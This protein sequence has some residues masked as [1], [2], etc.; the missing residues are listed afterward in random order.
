MSET[1]GVD[2]DGFAFVDLLVEAEPWWSDSWAYHR[3]N[4]GVQAPAAFLRT[5]AMLGTARLAA[6]G[7]DLDAVHATLSFLES[8]F[9]ADPVVD[10]L[11]TDAYLA[12]LPD[13]ALL[14]FDVAG[15][16][17]PRLAEQLARVRR[18]EAV[19]VRSAADALI[20]DLATADPAFASVLRTHLADWGE[21]LPTSY[22]SDL[23]RACTAWIGSGEAT[24]RA[25]VESV[26]AALDAAYGHD[27]EV[28][29]L[30]ATG[31][32]ENLPYPHEDG[33]AML[34]L[35]GPRLRAEYQAERPGTPL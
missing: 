8:Q 35:L 25:R 17:G 12:H 33:A 29:E 1:S 34:T 30:I 19:S 22:L 10:T 23:V 26:L 32:V 20:P 5:V 6:G 4:F 18:G 14:G 28:D 27:F 3:D 24:D 15:A 16:L 11:I 9:G 2:A 13:P 21:L 31:F 7:P